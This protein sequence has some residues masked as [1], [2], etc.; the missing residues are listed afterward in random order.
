VIGTTDVLDK[1]R[2]EGFIVTV[3]YL[4]YLLR[5]RIVATPEKRVGGVLLWEEADIDRLKYALQRRGR[6]PVH[7][8][9]SRR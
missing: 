6:G 8:G 4:N 9:G 1:L 2:E 7:T 3:G 5:E